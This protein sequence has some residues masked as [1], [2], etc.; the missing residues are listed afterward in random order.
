MLT[1]ER[2]LCPYCGDASHIY[3]SRVKTVLDLIAIPFLLRPVR[4]HSCLQRFY[5]PRFVKTLP[6]PPLRV[7]ERDL[8]DDRRSA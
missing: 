6:P 5:R 3:R 2:K 1:I 4:C 7:K 8:E